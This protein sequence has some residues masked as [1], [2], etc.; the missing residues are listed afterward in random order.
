MLWTCS[1]IIMA[2]F[3]VREASPS[4]TIQNWGRQ[5]IVIFFPGLYPEASRAVGRQICCPL[6]VHYWQYGG[7]CLL[8][9]FVPRVNR[10]SHGYLTSSLAVEEKEILPFFL[11][12]VKQVLSEMRCLLVTVWLGAHPT[13]WGAGLSNYRLIR[14]KGSGSDSSA[15]EKMNEYS[16][17]LPCQ[18]EYSLRMTPSLASSLLSAVN[19]TLSI[20]NVLWTHVFSEWLG[21]PIH[22]KTEKSTT[23]HPINNQTQYASAMLFKKKHK[24]HPKTKSAI[25]SVFFPL[26][27]TMC[28]FCYSLE[29]GICLSKKLRTPTHRDSRLQIS[30]SLCPTV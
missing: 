6:S 1:K 30:H 2:W 23:P 10:K 20:K 13:C 18:P 7:S 12:F 19:Q 26:L 16:S 22:L 5:D 9:N 11:F 4:A 21:W 8:T 27:W 28:M 24:K 15:A 25:K 3:L 17:M 29:K 14:S